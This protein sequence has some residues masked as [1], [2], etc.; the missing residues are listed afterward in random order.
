MTQELERPVQLRFQR[1]ALLAASPEQLASLVQALRQLASDDVHEVFVWLDIERFHAP[2]STHPPYR[3]LARAEARNITAARI[4]RNET[5]A[6]EAMRAL[7]GHGWLIQVES[8]LD[9]TPSLIASRLVSDEIGLLVSEG[10]GTAGLAAKAAA[11][12]G[13]PL[14]LVPPDGGPSGAVAAGGAL[15]RRPEPAA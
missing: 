5:E 9:A 12:G 7:T 13:C 3:Q 14:L 15:R 1:V 11:E 6:W 2:S 4:A 10:E 8:F